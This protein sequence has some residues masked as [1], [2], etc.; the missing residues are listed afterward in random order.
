MKRVVWNGLKRAPDAIKRRVFVSAASLP[1][2]PGTGKPVSIRLIGI[3]HGQ[4][5]PLGIRTSGIVG[6]ELANERGL[7]LAENKS[8]SFVP[9]RHISRA[10]AIEPDSFANLFK[11]ARM[12]AQF[13]ENTSARH[14]GAP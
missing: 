5:L 1:A 12:Q 3:S 11:C 2:M 8:L 4:V 10:R 14:A 13:Y 9:L 6:K 7:I